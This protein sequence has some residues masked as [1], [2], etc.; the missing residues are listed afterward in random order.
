M[1]R[2]IVNSIVT[3]LVLASFLHAAPPYAPGINGSWDFGTGNVLYPQTGLY[4]PGTTYWG[5]TFSSIPF[6]REFKI[7]RNDNWTNNWGGG[8]WIYDNTVYTPPKSGAN[9]IYKESSTAT[10]LFLSVNNPEANPANLPLHVQRF[11]SDPVSVS[12]TRDSIATSYIGNR[13]YAAGSNS[14]IICTLGAARPSEQ[15]IYLRYTLDGWS[16]STILDITGGASQTVLTNNLTLSYGQVMSYY[17]LTSARSAAELATDT[18]LK[19]VTYDT[20][21]GYNYYVTGWLDSATPPLPPAS[22]PPQASPGASASSTASSLRCSK[23]A[24][25]I[26]GAEPSIMSRIIMN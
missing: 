13:N 3:L 23:A 15:K 19:T 24:T 1:Q 10:H 4:G 25:Q 17:L 11:S 6:N 26:T 14:M 21:A 12:W 2:F 16:S 18:D 20:R 8:Y 9:M 7:T 22:I 5:R